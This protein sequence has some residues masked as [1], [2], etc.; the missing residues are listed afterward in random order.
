MPGNKKT[1]TVP[2]TY[3]GREQAYIK[4][5]L[6]KGYLE[7][8]FLI[9]GMSSKRLGIKEI[10]YVDCFAG[11]WADESEDLSGTSIAV[12]LQS[13]EK[14]RQALAQMGAVPRFR[15]LYV[16]QDKP[17]FEHLQRYLSEHTPAEIEARALPGDFVA[18][19]DQILSWCGNRAF[20]FF[21]IDP[22]GWKEVGVEV[23]RPLL[24]RP[25]SEFLINFMYDF[26]NRTASMSGWQEDIAA[27]LGETIETEGLDPAEREELLLSTYRDNLKRCVRSGRKWSARSAYVRVLDRKKERPKYHLV[28]LT[29]HPRGII[30][31]MKISENLDQ[32][33]KHV[34][35]STKHNA[36][37]K[38]SGMDDLF[39]M[40]SFIDP[41]QGHASLSEVEQYWI[42]Y[43]A[44][45][46]K[47]IDEEEFA[48]LLESTDWFPADFQRALGSLIT[49]G[50]VKNLDARGKRR[51]NFLHFNDGGERL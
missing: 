7:K 21:F 27:L 33:Q 30:E 49:G 44:A 20:V 17:A 25:Q 5:E 48:N 46:T 10:C 8:L 4:H 23:L 19:R 43:L 47:R 18:L 13:L 28:Y 12:S 6:L 40:A 36:R 38:K 39:G 3:Q 42:R 34:R 15:A 50:K 22:T 24:R 9:V 45:G 2:E 32:V 16:E 35:A 26:V 31:F 41:E 29:S 51:K 1:T 11:P 37:V 14:T